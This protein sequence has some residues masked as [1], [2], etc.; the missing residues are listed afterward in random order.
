MR[1]QRAGRAG[2]VGQV[3]FV[4]EPLHGVADGVDVFLVFL[5][6]VG[7]VEAQVAHAAVFLGQL[8]VEPDALGVADV[9]VAVGL[10]RKAHADLGRIG[11]ALGR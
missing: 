3:G 2:A 7:V 6:G 11:H 5:L 9:Q 8:E 10:G 4:A 1:L